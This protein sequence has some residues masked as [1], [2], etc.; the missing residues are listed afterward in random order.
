M[1][2]VLNISGHPLSEVAQIGVKCDAEL[3]VDIPVPNAELSIAG[4]QEIANGIVE[5]IAKNKKV[6][7]AVKTN[8]YI[9]FLPGMG[10]IRDLVEAKLHG[11][12]GCF[13]KSGSLVRN[14]DGIFD[15]AGY[16]DLQKIRDE[17]RSDFRV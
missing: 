4:F 8:D 15:Y 2:V 13:P 16:I 17:A 1:K 9:V 7:A 11:I 5:T 14:E 3:L 6:L 10:P 12:A